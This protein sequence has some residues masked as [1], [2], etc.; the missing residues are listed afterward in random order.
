MYTHS[1]GCELMYKWP[2]L[3]VVMYT[4]VGFGYVLCARAHSLIMHCGSEHRI[5]LGAMGQ[6]RSLIMH[7]GSEQRIQLCAMGQAH[8]LIMHCGSEH[9]IWLCAMGQAHS[10]IMH[11]GSEHRIWLCA[12]GKCAESLTTVQNHFNFIQEH[13]ESSEAR[14]Y[15]YINC[16]TQGLC[17]PLLKS[18]L[19]GKKR[20]CT[21]GYC[22]E[23]DLS[24]D[25]L[26]FDVKV[27]KWL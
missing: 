10:L 25:F 7:C 5:Q 24:S 8:S 21:M 15:P 11:C 13:A 3:H 14:N 18:F 17:H 4:R 12:K 2:C 26:L 20:F 23:Y 16:T 19:I 1:R 6:A 27:K 9:R 22:A